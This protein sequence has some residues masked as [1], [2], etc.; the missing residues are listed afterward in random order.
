M[1]G[2]IYGTIGYCAAFVALGLVLGALGPTLPGLADNTQSLLS[3]ISFLFTARSFGY[4]LGSFQG[5]RLYDRIPGHPVMAGV[6][7][8]MAV[9]MAL[10]PLMS[11][12]WL[13]AVVLLLSG[14]AEGTLDVGVNTLLIWVHRERVS[15]FMNALHFFFGVGA[16]LSPIVVARVVLATGD[17]AWAYWVLSFSIVPVAVW[18]LCLRSPEAPVQAD[19]G[20]N[21]KA[22]TAL[23]VLIALFFFLSVGAEAGMGGWVF[24]YVTE[25]GLA[26]TATAAYLNAAFWGSFTLGRLLG[27]PIAARLRPSAILFGN[28]M[29]CLA[30][31][32]VMLFWPVSTAAVWLG[33]VGIGLSIGP[34]FATTMSFAGRLMTIT[35]K[36]TGGFFV[37]VGAGSMALPWLIGQL[38]ESVGPRVMVWTILA[39]VVLAIAVFLA[40]MLLSRGEAKQT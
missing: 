12:L 18:L 7:G 37:G 15:P 26:G 19:D 2:R 35:G 8:V 1:A 3:G 11:Q 9:M 13:L 28:L 39:A 5:G 20:A 29:L 36:V 4:L 30:G 16:F 21:G 17:L 33:V 6:L 14:I 34:L 31:V 24:T 22:S 32:G 25:L 27:I 38:F 23:I 40:M 10:V